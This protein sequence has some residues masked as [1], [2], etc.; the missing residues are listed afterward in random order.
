MAL[1][2]YKLGDYRQAIR[3][4]D[5]AIELFSNGEEEDDGRNSGGENDNDS[6]GKDSESGGDGRSKAYWIRAEARLAPKSCGAVEE[7]MALS[8]LEVARRM[9]PRSKAIRW[10]FLQF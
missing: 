1:A 4:C 8:D 6:G 10:V 9:N 7:E 3:A 2:L 5:C